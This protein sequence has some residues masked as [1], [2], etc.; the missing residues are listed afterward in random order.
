MAVTRR[1]FMRSLR[2]T[3]W[4]ISDDA[5]PQ[6]AAPA[7]VIRI[8]SNENPMGPGKAVRDA[9][10]A[11]LDQSNRY[12]MNTRP[13]MI[14]LRGVIAKKYGGKPDNVILGDGSSEILTNAVRAYTSATRP[15]LNASPSY[16]DP[17]K[18]ATLINSPIKHVPIG[19]D[20]TLDLDAMIGASKGMGLI[21][22]CNPNNP[23]ATAVG[24]AGLATFV[25][26]IRKTSPTTAILIDEAYIDYATAPGV[27]TAADLALANPRVLVARTF[28][29][30]YGMANLRLGYT[31]GDVETIRTI[32][33]YTMPYNANVMA[34]AAAAASLGDPAHL[35]QERQRNAAVRKFTVDWFQQRGYRCTD[36][37][38]NF[39]F[40]EIRSPAKDFRD[41]CSAQGVL[42]GRDFPPLEKTHARISLGTMQEMQKAVEV[43][44]RVLRTA[45]TAQ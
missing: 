35:E 37:Q 36:S 38:S 9:L 6:M 16:L 26:A 45:P 4:N 31:L 30:G 8:S 14:D 5:V 17:E 25:S 42:V 22:I 19:P 43:F 3:S 39:L 33:K 27:D 28:S 34:V 29:K 15:L 24:K 21:F 2:A 11:A 23:T 7:G 12:P 10:V 32:D 20:L 18:T 44:G 1:G 13:A 40:V 41:G